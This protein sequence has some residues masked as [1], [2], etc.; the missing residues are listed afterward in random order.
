MRFKLR[1][2]H[3]AL[4]ALAA[5]A[6]AQGCARG[7]AVITDSTLPIRRV[8]VYRNGVG[9]FERQ[10][11]VEGSRIG[12]RVQQGDV[13]DFLATLAVMERGGSSVR[14]AAFPM[15]AEAVEG[16]PT[17]SPTDRRT[18]SLSLDGR[19]HDLVVGYTV[20]TPI[21]RPS[22]RLIFGEGGQAQVQAWGIVQNVSGEDWHDVQ[23]ALVSGAP[24]SFRSELATAVIPTRPVV[25]DRGAVID[26]VP[27]GE[28]TLAQDEAPPPPPP[29]PV[30][31]PAAEGVLD[32]LDDAGASNSP[33]LGRGAGGLRA[34]RA[35]ARPSAA[36]MPASNTARFAANTRE[37]STRSAA[38]QAPRNLASLAALAVQ[39][40]ATRYDLPQRVT[41]PDH[42]ATMVMLVAREIPGSRT[43]LFAPDPGVAASSSHPFHVARFEN[44]TGALLERGPIAIFE[45]GAFLGQGMLETLPDAASATV[46]FSLE[47]AIAVESSS[48]WNTEGQ[49]LVRI[50]RAQV[51]IER[52]NVR[53]TTWRVRNGLEAETRVIVR[54][55]LDGARLFEPPQGTEESNG[56]ALVPVTVP[57]HG[58]AE[59]VVVTRSAFT[60]NLPFDHEQSVL[61][62]EA[63]LNQGHAPAAV[64]TTLR[65]A[66]DMR[67]Q[68]QELRTSRDAAVQ[69]RD[70]LQRNAE[71]TRGNL[72]AIE[73]NPSAADL[74]AQ[75]TSRLS[76]VATEI[77][78]A[79]RR[80]VELDTQMSERNVRLV[81]ALR[82]LSF[83]AAP[84]TG[85]DAPTPRPVR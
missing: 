44:R 70:D 16:G 13:G 51:S 26:S 28:T 49:R 36:P 67:R 8:V 30:A 72:R 65:T 53:R 76:R 38:T 60:Q 64:A 74:R 21:W 58:N 79:T 78:Q 9:Y 83:E 62:I 47:R 85:S 4:A 45:H 56:N 2:M 52:Y 1:D 11:H 80:I 61:A 20:E 10:G 84:P 40:G 12:F 68:L 43:Y 18:V 42:S 77:D 22:Y 59:Q 33:G 71:E 17:P 15:P 7:P 23:L 41:V 32:S 25:T 55:S 34:R 24:V 81:E 66:L 6:A 31:T 63:Y 39:G 19:D 29:A 82:E 37:A 50:Q 27:Q 14:A 69:R 46:P 54:Q 48:N 73:R 35:S 5:L 57:G 3:A 75:L